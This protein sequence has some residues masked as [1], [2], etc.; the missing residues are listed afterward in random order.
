MVHCFECLGKN[1]VVDVDSGSVFSVDKPAYEAICLYNQYGEEEAKKR[2]A[3]DPDIFDEIQALKVEGTLFSTY[4]FSAVKQPK[5]V[6]KA[7]CLHIAHDCD[8]RCRYC[9]ASTGTFHGERSLMSAETGTRALDFLIAQSGSRHNLEVDFFGG[10]PLLNL[11]AVKEIVAYGRKREEEADKA[12]HFTVTTNAMRLDKETADYLNEE[13]FNIV[14]SLDGRKEVHDHMRPAADGGGSYDT[15]L[16]NALYMARI[17]GSRSYYVRGTF[18]AENLDFADDVFDLYKAGFD[19][20]S[21]EPVVTDEKHPYALREEHLPRIFA[22]YEALA[23]RY[24]ECR[25]RGRGF[26]FF[27][28]MIDKENGPCISKRLGGCGAGNEYVAI[29]PSGD[30]YPCHQFAG[31]KDFRMGSLYGDHAMEVDPAIRSRFAGNS[32]LTKP[33]CMDC[34]AKYYCSGG[35]SANGQHQCGDI[36]KPYPMACEMQRK[37]TECALAVWAIEREY[38]KNI[39]QENSLPN[40]MAAD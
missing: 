29:T 39:M 37:R 6:I 36:K 17:R 7:L 19:Q 14:L 35:C 34:W 20:I 22:E 30:I 26:N 31:E 3:G 21:I 2:Y 12:I 38:D 9:F 15:A 28:F 11:G 33:A 32:V 18:T 40:N 10:E 5:S 27:H 23:K 8:L 13:M 1:I 24:I 16:Q 25:R 4:D